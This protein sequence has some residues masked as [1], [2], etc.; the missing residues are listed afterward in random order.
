MMSAYATQLSEL[1]KQN[2]LEETLR[3]HDKAAALEK[4]LTALLADVD[5]AMDHSGNRWEEWGERAVT[6]GEMLDAAVAKARE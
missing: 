1:S 2:L 6:V 4:K 5:A 3:Q